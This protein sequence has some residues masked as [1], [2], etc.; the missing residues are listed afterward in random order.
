MKKKYIV[1]FIRNSN[2]NKIVNEQSSS[3]TSMTF[4]HRD[5]NAG[6]LTNKNKYLST[7]VII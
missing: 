4:Y 5:K 3:Y 6:L 2:F 7:Y 1:N